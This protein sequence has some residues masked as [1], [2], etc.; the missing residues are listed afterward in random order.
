MGTN[1]LVYTVVFG[2]NC[3]FAAGCASD[4]PTA[5]TADQIELNSVVP[6]A[7]TVL[8]AGERVTFTA[9]VTGTIVS[10]DGGFT[11][12]VL[13]DQANRSLL[14]PGEFPPQAVLPKGTTT[15]TLS[16]TYTIPEGGVSL[17]LAVPLF[18]NSSTETRAVTT[19]NYSTR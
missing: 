13:Q 4:S 11:G 5:P 1:K 12:M 3:F 7:G 15:V 6:A 18:T 10:S 9:V 8:R 17:T 16:H 2:L 19:R 14:A